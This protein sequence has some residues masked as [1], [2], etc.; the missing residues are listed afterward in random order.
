MR[1]L[2]PKEAPEVKLLPFLRKASPL[3]ASSLL[4]TPFKTYV[5]RIP[6]EGKKLHLWRGTRFPK[7]GKKLGGRPS[8]FFLKEASPLAAFRRK[9]QRFNL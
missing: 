9:R 1:A 6:K 3:A 5:T 7:E 8:F 4:R 2:F